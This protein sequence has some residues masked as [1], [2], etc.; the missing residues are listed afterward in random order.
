MIDGIFGQ[1]DGVQSGPVT[2][3]VS[4]PGLFYFPYLKQDGIVLPNS[5][6]RREE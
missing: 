6:V 3:G 2:D 1:L 4:V 5:I